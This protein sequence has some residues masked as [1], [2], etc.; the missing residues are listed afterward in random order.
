MLLG[1]HLRDI[2]ATQGLQGAIRCGAMSSV[3]M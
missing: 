3:Q 1:E 2:D